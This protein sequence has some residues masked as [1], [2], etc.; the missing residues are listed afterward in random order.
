MAMELHVFSD[1]QFSSIA[2]WQRA[3]DIEKYPLRLAADVQFASAQGFLPATLNGRQTGFECYHDDA[4]GTMKFL[5]NDHFGHRWG[6]A[7]GFRWRGDFDEL[8][9]AWMAATAYAAGTDGVI[10]DHQEGKQFTPA[11]ARDVI[12]GIIRDRPRAEAHVEEVKRKFA[13]K[14]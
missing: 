9:A 3:I 14:S 8:E 10:F 5:G 7:L 12:D 11:Q 4:M 13:S 1:R 2:E 6:F